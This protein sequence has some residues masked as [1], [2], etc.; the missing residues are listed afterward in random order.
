MGSVFFGTFDFTRQEFD[1]GRNYSRPEVSGEELIVYEVPLR[2]FTAHP[3]S[4]VGG[5]RQG[6]FLGFLDKVLPPPAIDWVAV[7]YPC[8]G[9]S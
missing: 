2:L 6:T 1:W 9:H 4:G 3:N 5:D 8:T 7:A